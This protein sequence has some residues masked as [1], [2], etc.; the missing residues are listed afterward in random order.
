MDNKAGEDD[1]TAIRQPVAA[2]LA[3]VER[4]L[5]ERLSGATPTVR[6]AYIHTLQA[7]GKRLRPLLVLLAAKSGVE[8]GPQAVKLAVAIE[9][10]HI[11]SM[12]HD[13]VVDHA[14]VRRG[15]ASVQ[16]L[17]DN[18]LAVLTGDYVVADIYH[19]LSQRECSE[20]LAIIAQA[21][22]R[23]CNAE[24]R[25]LTGDDAPASEDDY[26]Q[27]IGGKTAALIAAAAKVGGHTGGG[28]A[29]Q[30]VALE[31]YGHDL[32]M[33]F[34]IGDDLLDLYGDPAALGKPVGKDLRAGQ[35]TLPIIFACRQP[36]SDKLRALL[37]EIGPNAPAQ[38]IAQAA[39]LTAQLGGKAYAEE[40][41]GEFTEKAAAVTAEL[42]PSPAQ[43]ALVGLAQ[44][45]GR[46]HW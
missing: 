11:A 16:A 41:V 46:R 25:E 5:A 27:I 32:G 13:D 10:V 31:A 34:Q 1:L 24:A 12:L 42:P 18:R 17:W 4:E 45:V 36:G 14:Q 22:V 23:M 35:W 15:Q 43:I 6:D 33:A 21:V 40:K 19:L 28:S 2:E 3:E 44:F 7:G 8:I 9:Q 39:E 38:M 30:L 26:F 37:G 29:E 20:A